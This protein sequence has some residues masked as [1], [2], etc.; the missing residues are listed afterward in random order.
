MIL[1][2][3]VTQ[4]VN[5][6]A[7][8]AFRA[9]LY[10]VMS[11]Y[12]AQTFGLR[13]LGRITGC[14]FTF[15]AVVNVVQAPIVNFMNFELGGDTD[16]IAAGMILVGLAMFV[17]VQLTPHVDDDEHVKACLD[18]PTSPMFHRSPSQRGSFSV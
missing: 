12:I 5:F 7:F 15:G 3:I 1:T 6:L 14:V 8:A 13:T 17:P 2:P 18:S 10:G 16:W 4:V 9:Y 11:A